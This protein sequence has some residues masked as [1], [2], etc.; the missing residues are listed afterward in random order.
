VTSLAVAHRRADT[1]TTNGDGEGHAPRTIPETMPKGELSGAHDHLLL[2]LSQGLDEIEAV[3]IATSHRLKALMRNGLAGGVVEKHLVAMLE[4]LEAQEHHMELS[5]QATMRS[6]PLG[7][8]VRGASG[9][10]EKQAARLLAAIGDPYWHYAEHRPRTVSELWAYAGLHTLPAGG[11]IDPDTHRARAASRSTSTNGHSTCDTQLRSAVGRGDVGG[12]VINV[13]HG[14]DAPRVAARRKKG[15]KSNWSTEA[16][17]RAYLVAVSCVMNGTYYREVFDQ[18][19]EKYKD[20]THDV[21]CAPCGGKLGMR[22]MPAAP[23]GSPWRPGHQD[24]AAKRVVAKAILRDLWR[25]AKRLHE[26]GVMG[27]PVVEV[28][29]C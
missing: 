26:A 11:Q 10:G 21:P 22:D 2:I 12:Q 23:I 6:H 16:K 15:Q 17:T 29:P 1:H 27:P 3:R 5:L 19:K 13:T 25:E 14:A 24:A 28:A 7:P 9:V 8:W 20:R 18:A 4:G